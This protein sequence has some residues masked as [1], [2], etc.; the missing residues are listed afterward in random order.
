MGQ[1]QD[2]ITSK[3]NKEN[4]DR[5]ILSMKDGNVIFYRAFFDRQHSQQLFTAL[6]NSISWQ[7]NRIKL[8]GKYLLEPRLTAYYGERSY[9]Y[10]G[11]TRQPLL[12][13][14]VLLEIKSKIEPVAGVKFNA[15]LLNL[16]RHGSDSMGWHSDDERE[17]GENSIIASVS[18]G[19]T[20]RFIFRRK[21]D[22]A[23]KVELNLGDGDLLIMGGK[24][25]QFWQHQVPKV[26]REV[27]PRINLT[28]RVI[29]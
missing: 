28:F 13:T 26:R 6:N 12:W 8:F 3:S 22:R 14:P 20:R 23:L 21:N 15:V 18:F 19:A 7:Q 1:H 2:S 17:L 16:Y 25:Q 24:T 10:S 4:V 27:A 9:C 5:E 29:I 11:V